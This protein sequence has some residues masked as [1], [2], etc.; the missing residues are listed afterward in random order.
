MKI[1]PAQKG[2]ILLPLISAFAIVAIVAAGYF[3]WQ[4]Q[5]PIKNLVEKTPSP[6]KAETSQAS[7][8]SYGTAFKE[9]VNEKY[10]YS[11]SAPENFSLNDSEGYFRLTSLSKNIE[12][13]IA[14]AS[15]GSLTG[16]SSPG[17]FV[18]SHN[19]NGIV[20]FGKSYQ[21]EEYFN[22]LRK[23]YVFDIYSILNNGE[24]RQIRVGGS[25]KKEAD[26]NL[27][28]QILSTF[29][30]QS[31][32]SEQKQ[33]KK[34]ARVPLLSVDG[35]KEVQ[36][37]GVKF[38]IPSDIRY[39]EGQDGKSASFYTDPRQVIASW[40]YIQDYKGG[41]RREQYYGSSYKYD[42]HD[43]FVDSL[44]GRV[45]GLQIAIDGGWCQGGGGVILVVI[46]NKLVA[47]PQLTYS[48]ETKEISRFSIRDT[49]ISTLQPL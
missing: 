32:P 23:E 14:H 8:N 26:K 20:I 46:G 7:D 6:K 21:P 49:I 19:L 24:D 2:N 27:V 15:E 34:L 42:C 31:S 45:Q 3:F 33:E 39:F 35:W 1:M 29:T 25:Y 16:N 38:K 48:F 36:L 44:F 4:N 9:F 22:T 18:P 30:F 41:S 17:E 13:I 10:H 37:N 47:F 43:V 11:I 28:V 5:Q 40:I 12:I